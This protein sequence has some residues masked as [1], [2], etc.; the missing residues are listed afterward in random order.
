MTMSEELITDI[1]NAFDPFRPLEPGDPLYVS[2]HDVRGN[3]DV[4]R[5]L[6]KKIVLYR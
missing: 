6:G 1:Y 2:C 5:E 3:D 4:F